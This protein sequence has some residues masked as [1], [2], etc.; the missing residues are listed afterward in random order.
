MVNNLSCWL[1]VDLDLLQ[2][3]AALNVRDIGALPTAKAQSQGRALHPPREGNT[4]SPQVVARAH[5]NRLA[6]HQSDVRQLNA[7]G[8]ITVG[9][10]GG[11]SAGAQK[12]RVPLLLVADIEAPKQ[13]GEVS[14]PGMITMKITVLLQGTVSHLR[15]KVV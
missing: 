14:A 8:Q 6:L 1:P 13:M 15:I 2:G 5:E 11:T 10:P 3:E 12:G 7:T 4:A 9:A